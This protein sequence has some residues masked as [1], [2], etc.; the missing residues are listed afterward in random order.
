MS[1]Q[2]GLATMAVG[3]PRTT[4]G[5]LR[6]GHIV[7][8]V[9]PITSPSDFAAYVDR[10]LKTWCV[11]VLTDSGE[12]LSG[13]RLLAPPGNIREGMRRM[14][15]FPRVTA[16][17]TVTK[18]DYVVVAHLH[19]LH[20]APVVLG[21]LHASYRL[22]ATPDEIEAQ[23]A[24]VRD[25][26]EWQDR[27]DHVDL[28]D[29]IKPLVS[30]T[31]TRNAGRYQ[32][33]E[34]VSETDVEGMT[35]RAHRFERHDAARSIQIEQVVEVDA[36][37][38]NILRESNENAEDVRSVHVVQGTAATAT[39][40][41]E[42]LAAQVLQLT[43]VVKDVQKLVVR[44]DGAKQLLLQQDTEQ[45]RLTALS[46]A[47]SRT[48]TV[49]HEDVDQETQAA[50][51]F[52]RNSAVTLR[53]SDHGTPEQYVSLN[54][55]GSVSL[56][57]SKGATIHLDDDE[58]MITSK[59]STVLVSETNGVSVSTTGGST[60]SVVDDAVVVAAPSCTINAGNIHLNGGVV[61]TGQSPMGAYG[62][63]A[64]ETLY[65]NLMNIELAV[66]ALFLHAKTHTHALTAPSSGAPT[67]PTPMPVPGTAPS[68]F[69]PTAIATDALK[70]LR[71]D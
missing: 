8:P 34:H 22:Q 28:T 25:P 47:D 21:A 20:V 27:H 71:G 53:R 38:S 58:V 52:G 60:V 66:K 3:E 56:K 10:C 49:L 32:E 36:T 54:P 26:N 5:F 35:L 1:D 24:H 55:D 33:F 41:V 7:S 13:C 29:P 40:T 48:F 6:A 18:G 37:R 43:Q 67:T 44:S 46:D 39:V 65:A 23:A 4:R 70:S 42:D 14:Y 45:L 59:G 57:S 51:T 12:Y 69:L 2:M 19:G 68:H 15:R 11:D 9:D 16:Q 30:S 62:V 61:R 31:T 63:P 64:I 17:G 50:L